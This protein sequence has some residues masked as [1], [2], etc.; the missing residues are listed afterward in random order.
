MA[1][2]SPMRPG[3]A[4]ALIGPALGFAW[5]DTAGDRLAMSLP[6]EGTE[7]IG[8]LP[9][10]ALVWLACLAGGALALMMVALWTMAP[11]QALSS[12]VAPGLSADRPT[13]ASAPSGNSV[14][15]PVA[16]WWW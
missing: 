4:L 9:A 12:A 15:R 14:A 16:G 8:S 2:R 1:E 5:L 13:S 6:T 7:L 10:P 3:F 11:R